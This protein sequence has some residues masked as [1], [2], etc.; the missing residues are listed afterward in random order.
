MQLGQY[1]LDRMIARGGMGE[2]YR[3]HHALLRRETA[4]KLMRP[5]ARASTSIASSARSSR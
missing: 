5:D 4:V 3:A 1:T 2:V